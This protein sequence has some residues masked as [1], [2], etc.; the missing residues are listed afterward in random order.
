MSI[1]SVGGASS[2]SQLLAAQ[3]AQAQSLSAMSADLSVAG[4]T[5]TSVPDASTSNALTGTSQSSLDSQTLQTLMNLT[6]QDPPSSDPTLASQ[7]S[8][9]SQSNQVE[10]GHQHHHH[11]VGGGVQ[12]TNNPSAS[13]A[14]TT[15]T[16]DATTAAVT[17]TS[18]DTIEASLA[19]TLLSV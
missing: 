13:T 6:Q 1:A 12:Q 18:S 16:A 3:Q 4:G 9:S 17:N 10:Q 5:D 15:N 19:S 11:H 7:S 14:S 2:L 8:Q